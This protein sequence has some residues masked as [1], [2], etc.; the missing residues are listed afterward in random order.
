MRQVKCSG[1]G[2]GNLK[3]KLSRTTL[4]RNNKSCEGEEPIVTIPVILVP[5]EIQLALTT[6]PVEIRDIRV[7]IDPCRC[8][9]H[10]TIYATIFR[11]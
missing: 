5:V 10:H 2:S 9:V 1:D 7:T 3:R 8:C 4:E 11:I 6:V